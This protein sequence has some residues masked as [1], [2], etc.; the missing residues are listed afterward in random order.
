MSNSD[1]SKKIILDLCGG[2]GS[3]GRPYKDAGYDY[4]LITL[5]EQDVRYYHPPKGVYGILAAPPCTEFTAFCLSRKRK[6][7]EALE[8]VNSCLNII[9]E[10]LIWHYENIG[11]NNGGLGGLKFWALENPGGKGTLKYFLGKP[12]FI[13]NPCDFGDSYKKE[14]NLWGIFT[15]PAPISQPLFG[16]QPAYF[17]VTNGRDGLTRQEVRAITP[18]GFA[19]AF[20]EANQ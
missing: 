17:R 18:P 19:R 5:P 7:K 13:F 9:H 4:R 12:A 10:C 8:V 6:Y 2:T 14:T 1:N 11:K 15:N 16:I 3:W 20:F